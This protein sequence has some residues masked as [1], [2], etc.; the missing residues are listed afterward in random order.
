MNIKQL[1]MVSALS[2]TL[3]APAMAQVLDP[4]PGHPR[5]NEIDN[6]LENQQ[7][8]IDA[9]VKDGQINAKQE[10]RDDAI[11][12]KVSQKLSADEAAHDGHITKAEQQQ[13]N[14]ALNVDSHHIY[15]QRH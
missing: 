1:I 10:A 11:D 3:A 8:R 4:V 13:L 2:L 15:H 9:G 7:D 6:R 12:S 14:H 5:I